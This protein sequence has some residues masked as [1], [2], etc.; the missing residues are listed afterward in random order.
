MRFNIVPLLFFTFAI[1][2]GIRLPAQSVDQIRLNNGSRIEGTIVGATPLQITIDAKGSKRVA[3]INEIKY[4]TFADEPAELTAGR[5]RLVAGKYDQGLADL[6]KLNPAD[7]KR[8]LLL[9]DLQFYLAFAESKLALSAGGD[10]AKATSAM[11]A[12]VRADANSFHFFD[13]AQILG[14]LSVAQGS[15]ENA[16]KYYGAISSKAPWPEYK[17][18]ALMSEARALIHQENFANAQKKFEA[19]LSAKSESKEARRQKLFATIGRGRCLAETASPEEGITLIEN[20]IDK[21]DPADTELFGRAYNAHGD[22]LRKAGKAKEAL[23]AYLHVDVL[24]YSDPEIHAEA[25]F[26]LSSLWSKANNDRAV[27]ARQLLDE[28]YSGS[29]WA[30]KK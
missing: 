2:A 17:M 24:F 9:R 22:C 28:R 21:N 27:A 16:V 4:V 12:F 11:L 5:N 10:K 25:L 7:L 18:K 6:K 8:P 15:F 29:I 23:M 19:V 13:A 20:V 14:D 26:H 30:S 1:S 3:K